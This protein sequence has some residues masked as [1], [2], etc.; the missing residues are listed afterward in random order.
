M[1]VDVPNGRLVEDHVVWGDL[2]NGGVLSRMYAVE[3]PDT[4]A[5][6]DDVLM[7]LESDLRLI[8]GSMRP[9]EQVQLSYFT[10]NAF[11]A[12][13]ARFEAKTAKSK[14]DICTGVRSELVSRFRKR[15]ATETL[16][17]GNVRLALSTKLPRLIKED[18]RVVRGFDEVFKVLR[19]SFEQRAR[20]FN[21]LLS[22]YGGAVQALDNLGHYDELVRFWSPSQSRRERARE[23]DFMRPVADLC[24]FSGLS[25]RREPDHGFYLDG[26]Y[27]GLLVAKTL[28]RGT[29]ARTM[30]AF[31]ALTVPN[32]RVVINMQPLGIEEEIRHEEARYSKLMSNITPDSP[33]LESEVG[34]EKHRDRMR[35][36]MRNK[37]IPFRAQVIV[38]ASDKTADGLDA[39]MEGLRA[40]LGKTGCEP[41][42]PSL[43]TATLGFFNGATPGVGPWVEYRDYFQKCNDA[44]NAVDLWPIGSTPKGDLDDA[45]WISDGEQNNL[46]GGKSFR[47]SQ[48]EHALCAG[49][50]NSGKSVLLQSIVLQTAIECGF[51]SV[52]DD[53]GSWMTTCAK[54]DPTCRSIVVRSNGSETFNLFDTDRLPKSAQHLTNATALAH[55]LVGRHS[56][57]DRDK[58][59][60]AILSDAIDETYEIAYRKWRKDN[61]EEHYSLCLETAALLAF[62]EVEGIE[63]FLEAFLEARANPAVF[64]TF[65]SRVDEDAALSLDRDPHTEHLVSSLA[66][67]KWTPDMFPTLFDLQDELH[68]WS[69]EPGSRAELCG[70]LADLLQPWLRDGRYGPIVDGASNVDLGSVLVR[71]GDPVKVVHFDLGEMGES[72]AELKSVVGFLITNQVRNHI[73]GM[74]RGIKKMVVVEELTSFLKVP[75]GDQIAVDYYERMRKYFTQVI[76]VIQHFSTL[77]EINPKVAKAIVGNASVLFLLRNNSRK[78]LDVLSSYMSEPLPEC[79]KD[80]IVRFAKPSAMREEERYAGFVYVALGGDRPS[81]TVGRNYISREVEEITSSSGDAWERKKR[82]LRADSRVVGRSKNGSNGD[83]DL[84]FETLSGGSAPELKQ[85]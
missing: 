20:F 46:I 5:F 15:M 49:S 3:F 30:D 28:P 85:R 56:D 25:P 34:L 36:L 47:G 27:F 81:Y 74:P 62:Q 65:E 29:C 69:L 48:P 52:I 7:D 37:I 50:T 1:H 24:R 4:S 78:D 18:G 70:M 54:L 40:A 84:V 39:K 55:L 61:P 82:A 26:Y 2:G 66:F 35:L 57:A 71:E 13:L 83:Q 51:I 60:G 31:L 79:I 9:D 32:V 44:V 23:I 42:E 22:S 41:W 45:D 19:R 67:S 76:S 12:P 16:I 14:M 33:S 72:E 63:T 8:L 58:L 21:L 53:G 64:S 75:N 38:I 59:R 43:S 10:G 77:L 73:Q 11:E 68:A 80:Q 6:D 17:Q